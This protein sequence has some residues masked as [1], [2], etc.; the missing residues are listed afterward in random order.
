[1]SMRSV[2]LAPHFSASNLVRKVPSET[3]S[4]TV[5]LHFSGLHRDAVVGADI[6]PLGTKHFAD[7]REQLHVQQKDNIKFERFKRPVK[8]GIKTL[9]SDNAT[10]GQRVVLTASIHGEDVPVGFFPDNLNTELMKHINEG[11]EFKATLN[12]MERYRAD[13]DYNHSLSVRLEYINSPKQAP[14]LEVRDAF[15][16]AVESLR[17]EE[18]RGFNMVQTIVPE[19]ID[20]FEVQGREVMERINYEQGLQGEATYFVD[21]EEVSRVV[22]NNAE[23]QTPTFTQKLTKGIKD[24]ITEQLNH[25]YYE[26]EFRVMTDQPQ[27]D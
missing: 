8:L 15:Q 17:K 7:N 2:P 1:M 22:V 3:S 11:H 14:N 5:P 20:T 10:A 6:R 24:F 19:D 12:G 21:D 13:G 26:N 16:A 25:Y 18:Y 4:Q 23:Y 27:R 9:K